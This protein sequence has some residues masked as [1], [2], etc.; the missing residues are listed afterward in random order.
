[1]DYA[2]VFAAGAIA[3]KAYP[4]LDKLATKA[5][6]FIYGLFRKGPDES[7]ESGA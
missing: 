7:D 3:V 4:A 2:I 5:R 6:D 1:M